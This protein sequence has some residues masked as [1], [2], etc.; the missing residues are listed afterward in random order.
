MLW[1]VTAIPDPEAEGGLTPKAD[2]IDGRI[3]RCSPAFTLSVS[4]A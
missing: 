3:H 2:A 1:R 4:V